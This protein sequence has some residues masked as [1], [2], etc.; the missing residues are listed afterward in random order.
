[1]VYAD[2]AGRFAGSAHRTL[3]T[4]TGKPHQVAWRSNEAEQVN[5]PPGMMTAVE[6]YLGVVALTSCACFIAYGLDKRRAAGGGRR[7]PE[8]TLHLLAFL[9]GWPGALVAQRQ[10]RHKT[11]K[12]SFRVV[13]WAVVVLHAGIVGTVAYALAGWPGAHPAGHFTPINRG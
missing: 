13:F 1:M 5:G 4:P 3:A 6:V 7:V 8:R 12:V 11:R 9:G 2:H 10:F